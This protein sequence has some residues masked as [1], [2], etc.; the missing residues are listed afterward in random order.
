MESQSQTSVKIGI[1]ACNVYNQPLSE[2]HRHLEVAE[3][4]K[5]K[6]SYAVLNSESEQQERDF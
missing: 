2:C 4:F 3:T 1:P 6:L 5:Q